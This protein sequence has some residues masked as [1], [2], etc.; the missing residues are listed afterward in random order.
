M[1][2]AGTFH[3]ILSSGSSLGTA[4]TN[5]RCPPVTDPYK[6]LQKTKLPAQESLIMNKALVSRGGHIHA[7]AITDAQA[8][9]TKVTTK[10]HC[11]DQASLLEDEMI[12]C[13]PKIQS[14]MPYSW[15]TLVR[16]M[17]TQEIPCIILRHMNDKTSTVQPEKLR[18]PLYK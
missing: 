17:A 12:N 2:C 8:W 16:W 5:P 10:N 14:T 15:H 18:R 3:R 9:S 7:S 6:K 13:K 1:Y 11:H 4:R